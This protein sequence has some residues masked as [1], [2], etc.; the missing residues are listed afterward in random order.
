MWIIIVHTLLSLYTHKNL[1]NLLV[2]QIDKK[3]QR[4]NKEKRLSAT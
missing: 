2:K 1:K 3:Q 4:K